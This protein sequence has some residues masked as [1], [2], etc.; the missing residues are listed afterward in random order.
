[1][2]F[3]NRSSG[4]C[5]QENILLTGSAFWMFNTW[6][7][8]SFFVDSFIRLCLINVFIFDQ[9]FQ[10]NRRAMIAATDEFGSRVGIRA[11]KSLL[12]RLQEMEALFGTFSDQMGPGPRV[13]VLYSPDF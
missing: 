6:M 5:T 3:L 12:R 13:R 9:I 2:V 1:M 7:S 4:L 8:I 11:W 10:M